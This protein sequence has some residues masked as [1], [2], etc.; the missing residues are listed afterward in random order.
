[1]RARSREVRLRHPEQ[2]EAKPTERT[3]RTPTT[4]VSAS[5]DESIGSAYFNVRAKMMED[6]GQ[7]ASVRS[8]LE[9]VR[10]LFERLENLRVTLAKHE[11]PK[12][13]GVPTL[14]PGYARQDMTDG[15]LIWPV[16]LADKSMDLVS[17]TAIVQGIIGFSQRAST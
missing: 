12:K 14:A 15:S 1:M 11:I 2:V 4:K 3:S 10:T 17:R 16:Y 8:A 7:L 5:G 6:P 13:N 9:R